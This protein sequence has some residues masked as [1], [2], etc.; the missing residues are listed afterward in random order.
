MGG[1]SGGIGLG[2]ILVIVGVVLTIVSSF[3]LGLVVTLMGLIAAGFAK[4]SGTERTLVTRRRCGPVYRR[5][6]NALD[7]SK[8]IAQERAVSQ[9]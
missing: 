5:P 2:G 9:W 6:P 3:W 8:S 1:S 7:V 4:G